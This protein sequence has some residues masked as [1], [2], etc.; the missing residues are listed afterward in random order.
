MGGS[1]TFAPGRAPAD[2]RGVPSPEQEQLPRAG[3]APPAVGLFAWLLFCAPVLLPGMQ[4]GDR[5]TARLYYPVKQFIA[6]GLRHGE[7]R[8]WD[9]WAEGG[10]SLLGQVTPGLLHPFTLLYL[11][12]FELAFSL[13]HLLALLLGGLGVFWLARQ[14]R[15]SAWAALLGALAFGGSGALVSAASS[16]LPYALGPATVPLALAAL[17]WCR[18]GFTC[19][20]LLAASALLALCAYAGDPQSLGLCIL[21]GGAWMFVRSRVS[22][23]R[24]AALWA[25]CGLLLSAPVALPG[26][27]QLQRSARAD[28]VSAQETASFS[29]TPAR[30]WGLLV[31]HAFDQQETASPADTFSEYFASRDSSSAFLGSILLGAPALLFAFAAGRRAIFPLCA[32][33]L[34]LLAATGSAFGVHELLSAIIPGFRYFRFAEKL[35]LPASFLLALAA[36]MGVERALGEGSARLRAAALLLLGVALLGAGATFLPLGSWL[37]ALGRTHDAELPAQLLSLLRRGFLETAALSALLLLAL[38][39]RKLFLPL[40]VVAF[41]APA[42]LDPMLAPVDAQLFHGHSSTGE[43]ALQIAGPSAGRWRLWVDATGPLLTPGSLE[44]RAARLLAGRESLLPQLQALDGLE[45]LAPYFSAPDARFLAALRGAHEQ[46]FSLF[47]VRLEVLQDRT[48]APGLA[49]SESGFL[50]RE[51]P[52][53]P[54]AFVVHSA[55][56]VSGLADAVAALQAL[57]VHADSILERQAFV[58]PPSASAVKLTRLSSGAMTAQ[59]RN[60]TDGLLIIGERFDPGWTAR[61]DGSPAEVLEVDL[62]A[63]GVRVPAGEHRVELRFFPRGL[64]AGLAL[65]AAT[66]AALLALGLFSR[67]QVR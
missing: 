20:R 5:D 16:N 15:C 24:F 31:P 50:L 22:G 61:L 40:A 2:N 66:T 3:W 49:E 65:L 37:R 41:V 26:F 60:A 46:I 17:F 47:G 9:P 33:A 8:F 52:E 4:L 10:V 30:L 58:S 54:R 11:L 32:A 44:P 64:W 23:L 45:G 34:F 12:P 6:Q 38:R 29:T 43:K 36:A 28:G 27:L 63:L 51:Y 1:L 67:R 42:F 35:V 21:I 13:N 18:A 39:S 62:A 57:D 48:P 19:L 14:L 56:A 53:Q 7:L 59:I 55:R 25:L